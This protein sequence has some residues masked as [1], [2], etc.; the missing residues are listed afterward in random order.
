[1]ELHDYRDVLEFLPEYQLTSESLCIDCVV[2]R[3][4]KDVEIKKSIAAIFREWNLIEYKSPGDYIS[5]AD[6]YKVYGYACLYTSFNK[7][8]IKGLSI[9]FVASR[10]PRKLLRH[11]QHEHGFAI[12]ETATGIYTVS[13]DIIP[14]QI[15]DSRRLSADESLWLKSLSDELNCD[16][17]EQ[18][19]EE[20]IRQ[21]KDTHIAAY[22]EAIAEA[23]TLSLKE[24]MNMNRRNRPTLE[25]VLNETGVTARAEARGRTEGE[26]RKAFSIAQNLVKLG[27]PFDTIVSA[28]QLK[29][30]KVKAL[31]AK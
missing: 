8:S 10:N 17:V 11:L 1:M 5:V 7:V 3:K 15:I 31:Y 18:I 13:G 9:S 4:T 6:F 12:E 29:P 22:L 23:N 30:E 25:E 28:T 16:E 19:S 26:A 21:K 2:I 27:I 14:I 24:A 20:I